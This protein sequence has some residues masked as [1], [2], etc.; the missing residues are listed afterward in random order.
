MQ[1]VQ[2]N[3]VFLTLPESVLA[4]VF[5]DGHACLDIGALSGTARRGELVRC[6]CC[7]ATTI[8]EVDAFLR[9]VAKHAG[10]ARARL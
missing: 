7:W 5:S 3:E 4:G 10:G 1:P 9:S 2:T 8:E 6:V